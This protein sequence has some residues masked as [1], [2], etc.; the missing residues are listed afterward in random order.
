MMLKRD[1][2][3]SEIV[4]NRRI[5]KIPIIFNNVQVNIMK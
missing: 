1:Y 5:I 4:I 3:V 2:T